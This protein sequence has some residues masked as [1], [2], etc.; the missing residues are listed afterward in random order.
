M[1]T[2]AT[3]GQTEGDRQATFKRLLLSIRDLEDAGGFVLRLRE[4]DG[5][6]SPLDAVARKALQIAL[7]V[8]YCRP[9][10]INKGLGVSKTL[11][12]EFVGRLTPEQQALHWRLKALRDQEFAHSDG[13][14][15][16]IQVSVSQRAD[17]TPLASHAKAVSSAK[18]VYD[19]DELTGIEGLIDRVLEMCIAERDRIQALLAPGARF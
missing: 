7:V 15:A 14:P 1:S 18:A 4:A 2:S 13:G 11:P 10:S 8:S 3:T 9:F 16:D 17:G 5:A 6:G 19:S 12:A